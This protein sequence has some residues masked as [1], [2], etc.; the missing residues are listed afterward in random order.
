M[1]TFRLST[2]VTCWTKLDIGP[3]QWR[4]LAPGRHPARI[5]SRQTKIASVCLLNLGSRLCSKTRQTHRSLCGPGTLEARLQ[6][7]EAGPDTAVQ[8]REATAILRTTHC[9]R[10]AGPSRHESGAGRG[11]LPQDI[12]WTPHLPFTNISL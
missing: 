5:R 10:G 1:D 12:T 4:A 2:L 8:V 9:D 11:S 7:Q 6:L 3:G